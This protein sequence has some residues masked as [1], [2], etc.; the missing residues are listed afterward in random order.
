MTYPPALRQAQGKH[1][2]G[3]GRVMAVVISH[4]KATFISG[5]FSFSPLGEPEA[6][7]SDRRERGL[8]HRIS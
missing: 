5:G 2:K 6:K 8:S 3:A 1:G 7:R 4:V